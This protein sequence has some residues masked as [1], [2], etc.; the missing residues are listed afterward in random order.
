MVAH[1]E[2]GVLVLDGPRRRE[3]AGEVGHDGRSMRR[4]SAR[5]DIRQNTQT[6]EARPKPATYGGVAPRHSNDSLPPRHLTHFQN[7]TIEHHLAEAPLLHEM[8]CLTATTQL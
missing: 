2:I 6:N 7:G 5:I 1:D 3:V 4:R 8:A